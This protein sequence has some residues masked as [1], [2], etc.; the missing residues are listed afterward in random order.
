MCRRDFRWRAIN[1]NEYANLIVLSILDHSRLQHV[2]STPHALPLFRFEQYFPDRIFFM[3]Y[4]SW[5]GR[6]CTGTSVWLVYRQ[7]Y[8]S[9]PSLQKRTNMM[10]RLVAPL[11]CFGIL[12]A[13]AAIAG[14]D[15]RDAIKRLKNSRNVE[16]RILGAKLL[17]SNEQPEAVEALAQA[18][19]D[20]EARV[21]QAAASALWDT[22]E[23]AKA[24]EPA[25]RKALDDPDPGVVARVAG[26]LEV[27]DVDEKELAPAR[28]RALSAVDPKDDHTAFLIA[29]GLIGLDPPATVVPSLLPYL[30]SMSKA[31]E[32]S[33]GYEY[34]ESVEAA[35]KALVEV[36]K[37]TDRA[38]IPMLLA[39]LRRSPA[40]APSLLSVLAAYKP[41]LEHFAQIL[42]EQMH[43]RSSK[44]R[45]AALQQ[46]RELTSDADAAI[47]APEAIALLGDTEVR[48]EAMW[49]LQEGGGSAAPAVPQI[50]R[51]LKE[52]PSANVRARAAETIG[53]IGNSS[54]AVSQKIKIDVAAQAK[55]ALAAAA[56]DKNADLA[57]NGIEAYNRLFLPT[58]E[59]VNTNILVAEGNGPSGARQKALLYLRNLSGKA[60]PVLERV[61][62]LQK[63][64]D[65]N[66]A[67]E[68][69]FATEWIEGGG[70][71]TDAPIG[72]EAK[73]SAS[74]ETEARGLAKLRAMGIDFN[75]WSFARSLS[76]EPPEAIQAFLDAGM[77][78]GHMLDDMPP[79]TFLVRSG[80]SNGQTPE[81]TKQKVKILLA[82]GADVN[83]IDDVGGN[84]ALMWAAEGCDRA[85]V[86]MLLAA[87]AKMSIRNKTNSSALEGSI[88]LAS[89]GAEELI[90]AGARLDPKTAKQYLEF[91]KDNPKVVALIKKATK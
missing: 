63:S 22:G 64:S 34:R 7:V 50:V 91:Y 78:P 25:L 74:P 52:D 29:R 67:D 70:K 68:A 27:M 33:P 86:R 79:L 36:A 18:L 40:S 47:W 30:A 5:R 3:F 90:A 45:Y 6:V 41:P 42:A 73:T 77:S 9:H 4:R 15:V 84:T 10:R 57:V 65:K 69:R 43:A 20:K 85:T 8:H 51:L 32:E 49:A 82:G 62:A 14:D 26:A 46:A 28:R 44:T 83:Q 16:D 71:G 48:M 89:P 37:T 21:R 59:I 19:Q 23:K 88:I 60:R 56:S 35:E 24:A 76:K 54:G 39:E 12:L 53:D 75:D 2:A 11:V 38:A 87:G 31:E 55:A 66:I 80:C 72:I 13:G 61:R 58:A 1:I 81:T 17:S